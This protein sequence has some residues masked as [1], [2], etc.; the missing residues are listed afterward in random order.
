M[1]DVAARAG[2]SRAL[3]STV[4]RNV[5][6]AS[7]ATRA[8][9]LQAA[10]ELGYRLDNRARV[11]RRSRTGQFGVMFQVHEAYH[12]DL[13]HELYNAVETAGCELVLSAVVPGRDEARAVDS[14]LDNRCEALLLIAP[15]M[16]DAGLEALA[17]RCPTVVTA[18]PASAIGF[19]VV[20]TDDLA[21][22]RTALDHLRSL[23]HADIA[24]VDGGDARGSRERR[25]SYLAEM[26]RHRLGEYA[27]VITGGLREADG[28]R[29]AAEMIRAQRVP[30]A[31]TTFNDTLAVGVMFGLRS[32]GWGVP[33]DVSVVGFDDVEMAALPHVG[34]STVGQDTAL[35]ARRII[36]RAVS[37][38]A[39]PSRSG[40][41]VLVP[42]YW[43]ARSTTGRPAAGRAP[44]C[45]RD[46]VER[47]RG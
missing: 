40:E 26:R 25:D 10:E 14:L 39:D 29:A 28:M 6:G 24:H 2:V 46:R 1:A 7:P 43:V 22:V 33:E 47:D 4:Y 38:I 13:V 32:A 23:G 31:V 19:D 44:S 41:Q 45:E 18:R 36:E 8:R 3:V 27:Q 16:E 35:T 15:Q 12:A 5:P 17:R 11:L 20:R 30:T 42:P 34:L 37:R 9:V 21:A